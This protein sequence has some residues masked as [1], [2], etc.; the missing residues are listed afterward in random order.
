MHNFPGK[1]IS[2]VLKNRDGE[3][4]TCLGAALRVK[5]SLVGKRLTTLNNQCALTHNGGDKELVKF[6]D[7]SARISFII[8]LNDDGLL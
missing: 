4:M 6:L 3:T 7:K 1:R 2:A 8:Y 5:K